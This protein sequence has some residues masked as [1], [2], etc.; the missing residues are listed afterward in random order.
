MRAKL[1]PLLVPSIK[2]SVARVS[3]NCAAEPIA[4]PA[5]STRRQFYLP[6]N[7]FFWGPAAAGSTCALST[8]MPAQRYSVDL[9]IHFSH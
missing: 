3:D 4:L 7:V 5:R 1:V 2:C 8:V 6:I 9:R